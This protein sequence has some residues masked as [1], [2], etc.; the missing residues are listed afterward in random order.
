[1]EDNW[2]TSKTKPLLQAASTCRLISDHIR[3]HACQIFQSYVKNKNLQMH[4]LNQYKLVK[5]KY[6]KYIYIYIY[7]YIYL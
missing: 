7:I 5:L 4:I 1:M 2:Y 3:E 6:I